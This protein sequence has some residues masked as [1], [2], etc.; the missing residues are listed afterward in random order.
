MLADLEDGLRGG[1]SAN[2]RSEGD[3]NAWAISTAV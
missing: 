3:G 2:L 1:R